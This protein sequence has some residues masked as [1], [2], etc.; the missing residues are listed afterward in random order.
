MTATALMQQEWTNNTD[1]K[2]ITGI[3]FWDL[4]AAYDTLDPDL[5]C[6]KIGNLWVLH[7]HLCMVQILFNREK[8]NYK[9]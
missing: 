7:N 2:E 8:T 9:S 1:E 6:I 3:L 5:I 4:S